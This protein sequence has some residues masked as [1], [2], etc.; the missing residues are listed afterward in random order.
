MSKTINRQKWI[1]VS[2][3]HGV[4]VFPK[5]GKLLAS[6]VTS[7]Q[8]ETPVYDE[9]DGRATKVRFWSIVLGRQFTVRMAA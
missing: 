3:L 4:E 7:N 2:N 1:L 8:A 9:R 5:I 6:E